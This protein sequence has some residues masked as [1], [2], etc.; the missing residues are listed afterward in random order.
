[1]SIRS[2]TAMKD[3]RDTRVLERDYTVALKDAV[4]WLGDR[5]LLATPVLAWNHARAARFF[6]GRPSP[7]HR[8]PGVL[9]YRRIIGERY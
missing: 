2:S 5:H 6:F 7:W 8:S 1:M 9:R 3:S 4:A